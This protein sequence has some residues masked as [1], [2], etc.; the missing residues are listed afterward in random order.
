MKFWLSQYI[1]QID[2]MIDKFTI[3]HTIQPTDDVKEICEV[4]I[5]HKLILQKIVDGVV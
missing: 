3:L 4:L 2:D 1:E 5:S